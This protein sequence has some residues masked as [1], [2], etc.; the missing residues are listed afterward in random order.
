MAQNTA[1]DKYFEALTET[2][3]A[4]IDGIKAA[5]ERGYRISN[6]LLAEAQRG[7]R[8]AVDLGKK[9][10]GAPSDVGGFY[11]AVME[12][13]TR[14]QGRTL[15]L[16]RQMFDELSDIRGETREAIEKIIKAQREAGEAAVDAVRDVAGNAAE[17]VRTGVGRVTN[18][19]EETT[20]KAT[21]STKKAADKVAEAVGSN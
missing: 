2:Y 4:I 17:R 3:D 9:F 15:E 18:Q 13:T 11:R 14:A 7:Q 12:S 20:T 6:S 16:A 8:E 10:A 21:E 19:T 1:S 5:N